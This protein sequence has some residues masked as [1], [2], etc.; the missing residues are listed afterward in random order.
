MF[1]AYKGFRIVESPQDR[2]FEVKDTHGR[3][4]GRFPSM[5]AAVAAINRMLDGE[6]T[7]AAS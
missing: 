3:T 4:V 7:R 2:G 6:P 5:T 1:A